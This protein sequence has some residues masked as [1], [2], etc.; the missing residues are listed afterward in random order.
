MAVYVKNAD[1]LES[2]RKYKE[3]GGTD[4]KEYNKIGKMFL[5]M[6]QR[7]MSRCN[8]INYSEDRREDLISSCCLHMIKRIDSFDTTLTS[9]F[10]Y[11]TSVIRNVILQ[12]L[13][14]YKDHDERFI[15]FSAYKKEM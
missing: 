15:T 14:K 13:N 11:F 1:L 9:P 12:G 6:A 10:S 3:S 5:L 2:L 4:R 7:F 8:L